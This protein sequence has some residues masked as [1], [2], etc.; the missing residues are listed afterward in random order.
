MLQPGQLLSRRV[1]KNRDD[2]RLN[3]YLLILIHNL[4]AIFYKFDQ[5]LLH[6]I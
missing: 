5:I 2:R 1:E 3:S 6:L 4:L